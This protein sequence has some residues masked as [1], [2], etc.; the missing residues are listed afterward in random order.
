[1]GRRYANEA[2]EE[3]DDEVRGRIFAALY[4]LIR[5][6]IFLALVIGPFL[7]V[8][9]D[10]LSEAIF[11]GSVTLFGV[12]MRLPG[13][14]WTLWLAGLIIIAAGVMAAMSLKAD[15]RAKLKAVGS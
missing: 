3:A 1:M 15:K 11:G 12:E 10:R 13:V 7:A 4:S 5:L 2:A 9:F 14:R 6:C 8:G